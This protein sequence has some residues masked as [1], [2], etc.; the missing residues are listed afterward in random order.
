MLLLGSHFVSFGISFGWLL[1]LLLLRKLRPHPWRKKVHERLLLWCL[2]K[3]LRLLWWLLRKLRLRVWPRT[4][5]GWW[6]R[7]CGSRL[8]RLKTFQSHAHQLLAPQSTFVILHC[9]FPIL[10]FIRCQVL[11]K[12]ATHIHK[13]IVL[14]GH[15]GNEQKSYVARTV[16]R[17][18]TQVVGRKATRLNQTTNQWKEERLFLC[19]F[20]LN[21]FCSYVDLSL[22]Y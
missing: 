22:L 2:L 3:A 20:V 6:R 13:R 5:S 12:A 11:R 1:L 18:A 14:R 4:G 16:G 9:K 7:R 10:F 19:W 17:K 8:S 15:G 21:M